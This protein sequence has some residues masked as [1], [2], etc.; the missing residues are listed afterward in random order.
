MERPI[1]RFA[2]QKHTKDSAPKKNHPLVGSF[3]KFSDCQ[4]A[5]NADNKQ[6]FLDSIKRWNGTL[7]GLLEDINCG[8]FV[9]D[10]AKCAK[11]VLEGQAKPVTCNQAFCFDGFLELHNAARHKS[12]KV[13]RL[14]LKHDKDGSKA[15]ARCLARLGSCEGMVLPL[16]IAIAIAAN[17]RVFADWDDKNGG[18]DAFKL[19]CRLCA[20]NMRHKLE[21]VRLLAQKTKRVE[22]EAYIY[23]MEGKVVELVILLMVASEKVL[24]TPLSLENNNNLCRTLSDNVLSLISE[25]VA[26][27][28]LLQQN[29]SSDDD[30]TIE[31]QKCM[32]KK[33]KLEQIMVLLQ[34]FETIGDKLAEYLQ[35]EQTKPSFAEVTRQVG[36]IFEEGG[37]HSR[38][39]VVEEDPRKKTYYW[40]GIICPHGIRG[41][42]IVHNVI[43]SRPSL[44]KPVPY[45]LNGLTRSRSSSAI[46]FSTA[47]GDVRPIKPMSH[48]IS[49][50]TSFGD[51]HPMKPVTYERKCVPQVCGQK[52]GKLFWEMLSRAIKHV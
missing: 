16:H 31:V 20:P 1:F 43:Q 48:A 19:I 34:I 33:A 41:G 27:L 9:F 22:R 44:L 37:I 40:H 51:V 15:N 46:S 14:L 2:S 42:D 11:A 28:V 45:R 17:E 47:V 25:V 8:I 7:P 35:L 24:R 29:V 13:M 21:I 32:E 39:D 36:R 6:K 52:F 3:F 4:L 30:T 49:F 10:A 38:P 26:S 5:L 12:L 18:I 50:A 23:A